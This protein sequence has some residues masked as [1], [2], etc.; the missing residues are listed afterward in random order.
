VSDRTLIILLGIPAVLAFA[1]GI[2]AGLGYPGL[3]DRYESTGRVSREMP[4][5][6]LLRWLSGLIGGGQR[7]SRGSSRRAPQER[8]RRGDLRG[9]WRR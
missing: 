9:R 5:K 2:W 6:R 1:F 8:S 4:F 7:R 3:Y